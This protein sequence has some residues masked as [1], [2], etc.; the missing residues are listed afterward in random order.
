MG[1]PDKLNGHIRALTPKE[2][3]DLGVEQS[4]MQVK[5]KGFLN[6]E[7]NKQA[8]SAFWEA[9]EIEEVKE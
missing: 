1:L 4:R 5:I 3:F 9:M 7:F 2:Y 8:N 6:E